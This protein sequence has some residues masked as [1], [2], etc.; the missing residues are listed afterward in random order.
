MP[1]QLIHIYTVDEAEDPGFSRFQQSRENI[2]RI[3]NDTRI[4][5]LNIYK[6]MVFPQREKDVSQAQLAALVQALCALHDG[7]VDDY[8]LGRTSA[9]VQ[10]LDGGT[11]L[12]VRM[13]LSLH[14]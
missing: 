7:L 6:D 4:I 13:L 3:L 5:T 1:P 11:L 14:H 9:R 10:K 2:A 12:D 8:C